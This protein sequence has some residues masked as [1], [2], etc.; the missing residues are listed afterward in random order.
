MTWQVRQLG[1][2]CQVDYGTRVV[3][4]RDGGTIYPVYGGGGETFKVDKSNRE[5]QLIV[6]RFAMSEE[7][8]RFVAGKFFLNDSGLTVSSKLESLSQ[9][10]LDWQILYKR[11][12]IYALGRGAAQRNLDIP[13][14]LELQI[15][16][17]SIVEQRRIV[18]LLDEAFAGISTAK[19][20]AEKSLHNAQNVFDRHL[21]E[22]FTLRGDGWARKQI[23]DIAEIKGGK[24]VPKGYKLEHAPTGFPYL[25]VTDFLDSGTV[26]TSDLRYIS[27]DIQQGIKNYIIRKD[28][29]YISIA[30]TI[31][32]TG[33]IPAELDGANLTEN[34][35]RL[36]FREGISN[37]YVYHF[38][39]TRDFL[40]QAGANTRTAAQPKLAL[41]R[42][43]TIEL[44][45]PALKRQIE[46]ADSFDELSSE[47]R[48]LQSI[49]TRK[50]AA[51]EELKQ[52]LLQRAFS[53]NL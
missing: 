33:I 17:P 32:K 1:E 35:C 38:T 19:A 21:S 52:S 51:L 36:V 46:L 45:L 41:A 29:L 22:V 4:R 34:A 24:R 10:F 25:R 3:Q 13:A 23:A 15:S 9:A 16:Y 12:E 8:V 53:G 31:G 5:D 37:R 40:D 6:S 47:T 2:V 49:Y 18:T 26:D 43:A 42:L 7:C 44:S 39:T 27:K 28:D 11:G 48:H 20:N 50:L 30:G 14:F